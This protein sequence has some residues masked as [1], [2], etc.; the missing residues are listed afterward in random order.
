MERLR[1]LS[2]L[3]AGIYVVFSL[4]PLVLGDPEDDPSAEGLFDSIVGMLFWLALS[5]G[6]IWYGDELGEGLVGA[7]YGLVSSPSPG[8]AVALIGWILLLLPAFIALFL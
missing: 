6:C 4:W 3:I 8:W 2:I 5:L 1:W 7:R